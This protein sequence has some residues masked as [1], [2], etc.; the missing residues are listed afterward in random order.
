MNDEEVAE[1]H[2]T[3]TSRR[4]LMEEILSA[5]SIIIGY[6][7]EALEFILIIMMLYNLD[8]HH[9]KLQIQIQLID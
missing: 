9:I 3:E 4:Q 5:P 6:Y 1:E 8:K 7:T 2:Q